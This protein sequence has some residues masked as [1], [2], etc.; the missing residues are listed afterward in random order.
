VTSTD[1]RGDL[2]EARRSTD[3]LFE[4]LRPG[5]LYDRPIDR[6][7]RLIFYL[8]HV[9]TF[10]WNHIARYG[11][12]EPPL[13]AGFDKLFAAGIDPDASG[14][15]ADE[16]SDWPHEE[17]VLDYVR[18]VRRRIDDVLEN[19]PAELVNMAIEHRLM[20]AETLAYGLHALPFDAKDGRASRVARS[21][22][23]ARTVEPETIEIPAGE[24]TL[25]QRRNGGFGWDN[26]FDEHQVA[27]PGFAI[28]KYKITNGDYLI[29]VR[30]G[31][32]PPPFWVEE[33]GRWFH[34]GMLEL[35]P[36]PL[37]APVYATWEQ[38]SAYAAWRGKRLLEEAEFHRAAYGDREG[39]ERPYPWGSAAPDQSRGNF[40]FAHWDPVAV[41]AHPAGES[42]FGVAQTVGN[43]WEWTSTAFA[44]FEGFTPA[45]NY[46]GYSKDFFDGQHYVLKGGSPRTAARLLRRSF[47]NWFRPDYTHVYATFRCADR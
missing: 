29:F 2:A 5:R 4:L 28:D 6:R 30:E 35:I 10:D 1:L 39:G 17:Q 32:A 38:A 16:A 19:A 18:R 26:E 7:H 34:R 14:L 44:P 24:A 45:P 9:D 21:D 43:G 37:D 47:R 25:G 41:D 46:A 20:H 33:D 31:G 3:R 36:L 23:G 13:D 22:A 40:D 27:V 11:L 8:G 42:A 12:S 15:P